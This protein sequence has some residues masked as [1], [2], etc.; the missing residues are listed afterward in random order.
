MT[1]LYLADWAAR[2]CISPHALAELTALMQ[3][4]PPDIAPA[5]GTLEAG[6][7]ARVRLDGRHAGFTLWRNNVGAL[8]DER[9][10]PVRY[11]LAN[12][13][14]SLN[15]TIKSGDLIGWRSVLIT[16]EHVGSTIAQFV[17]IECKRPDWA[18]SAT[19]PRETA[20]RRWANL[21][22]AS[23]GVGCFSTGGLPL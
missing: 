13:S 4:P 14:K 6:V 11:G 18:P 20:Q 3:L 12:D 15:E 1:P 19:D 16:P 2:N 5:D 8:R 10:V 17:S 7:Q 21:V 9:G 22:V 23:G